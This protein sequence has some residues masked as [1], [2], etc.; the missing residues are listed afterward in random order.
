[1]RT[2]VRALP[3]AATVPSGPALWLAL[4]PI[5]PRPHTARNGL[6]GQQALTRRHSEASARALSPLPTAIVFALR[7]A[8]PLDPHGAPERHRLAEPDCHTTV[9]ACAV[10]ALSTDTGA[11]CLARAHSRQTSP[12]ACRA[13]PPYLRRCPM[14]PCNPRMF[15]NSIHRLMVKV[16]PAG[17]AHAQRQRQVFRSGAAWLQPLI[18]ARPRLPCSLAP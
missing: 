4:G 15:A 5:T 16:T 18:P 17:A 13:K 10:V 2:P 12:A 11:F 8:S 14:S 6:V 7:V 3:T 9:A 1:M